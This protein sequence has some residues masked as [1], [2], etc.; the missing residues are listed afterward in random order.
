MIIQTNGIENNKLM[1]KKKTAV[2]RALQWL[3]GQGKTIAPN[4]LKAAGSITGIDSLSNLGNLI[5]NDTEL[6]D[7]DKKMLLAEIEIDTLEMQEVSNRWKFD[8]DS[9]N[10]LSK[11]IRPLTL[12]FLTVT[13]FI[14]ILLDSSLEGFKIAPEWVSLLGN[15]LMLAYGG[16]YGARSVEKIF[17]K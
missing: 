16:Y 1:K 11:N 10:K 13:M 2:G 17:K 8:M 3:I 6:S 4:I 7:L 12:A 14:Y 15:L 9:D 5:S